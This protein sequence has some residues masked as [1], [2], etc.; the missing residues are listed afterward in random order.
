MGLLGLLKIGI[1]G[2]YS[3][4]HGA[5]EGSKKDTDSLTKKIKDQQKILKKAYKQVN[6]D[7]QS[8]SQAGNKIT[9][10]VTTP[11]I[12]LGLVAG[13]TAGELE[14]Y[15]TSFE[16]LLKNPEL[17]KKAYQDVENFTAKTNLFMS[18]V[19]G[20]AEL[21]LGYE[22][23][24]TKL[25]R[26]L[27][28]LGNVSKGNAE[29]FKEL[30]KALGKVKT[31]GRLTTEVLNQFQDR[32]INL[33]KQLAKNAGVT[34]D[35]MKKMITE[36]QVT[37]EEFY[38]ALDDMANGTGLYA[39]YL[40]KKSA[41]LF[42]SISTM[43]DNL[44]LGLSD[45]VQSL[46]P[47]IKKAVNV[48]TEYAKKFRELDSAT[49]EH[50]LSVALFVAGIG[51]AITIVSKM[52]L[53]IMN[54]KSNVFNTINSLKSFA[55]VLAANPWILA[56]TAIA[57]VTLAIGYFAYKAVSTKDITKRL[58]TAT[59]HLKDVQS[60]YKE[61]VSQ[62]NDKTQDLNESERFSLEL[63]K[64]QLALK[65]R[66]NISAIAKEWEN[67]NKKRWLRGG[68]SNI[69]G[70]KKKLQEVQ[71]EIVKL[72]KMYDDAKEAGHAFVQYDYGAGYGKKAISLYELA[73]KIEKRYEKELKYK[74]LINNAEGKTFEAIDQI[75]TALNDQV[76]TTNDLFI[77]SS[78]YPELYKL[79]LDQY[80]KLEIR[81]PIEQKRKGEHS[82]L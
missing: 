31:N 70:D 20:N 11:L 28:N 40:E 43:I 63:R 33:L 69:E 48:V 22:V 9:T 7:L 2:D 1:L 61:V 56:A 74:T 39:N 59:R 67:L 53:V 26:T 35:A 30:T 65:I 13:K 54:L 32:G 68:K 75:A 55:T 57:G 17:A 62:L 16:A 46:L 58:T 21:L 29:D 10:F 64:K 81:Q 23:S 45:I 25:T 50:I 34:T 8:L 5:V 41:T 82:E 51:P 24:V 4:Y 66:E 37:Y 18:Q 14:D 15:R 72:K 78:K 3:S 6:R 38:Q 36:Q 19:A 27:R 44:K 42:G 80:Q 77:I 12:G 49:K 79:I 52:A 73:E 71:A 76:I 60:R 47:E